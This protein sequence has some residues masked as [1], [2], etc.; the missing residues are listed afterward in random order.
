MNFTKTSI[1]E[2]VVIEHRV[3]GDSRGYFFESFNQQAFEQHIGKFHFVQDNESRSIQQRQ[4]S[5]AV[6]RPC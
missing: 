1:P 6:E 4:G 5:T 3:F 2:V